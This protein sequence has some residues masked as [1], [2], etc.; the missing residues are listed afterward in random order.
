M[1]IQIEKTHARNHDVVLLCFDSKITE[2]F[3]LIAIESKFLRQLSL[4]LREK[5]FCQPRQY[6]RGHELALF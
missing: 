6:T 4:H 1:K 5:L 2:I 3:R